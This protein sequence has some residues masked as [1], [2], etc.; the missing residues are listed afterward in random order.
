MTQR[1]DDSACSRSYASLSAR[2]AALVDAPCGAG[3]RCRLLGFSAPDQRV[4]AV[5]ALDEV[6]VDRGR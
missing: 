3:R 2:P 5:L 6:G 1:P 4:A